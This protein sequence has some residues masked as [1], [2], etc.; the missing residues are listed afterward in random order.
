MESVL[1]VQK[2]FEDLASQTYRYDLQAIAQL[3]VRTAVVVATIL[4]IPDAVALIPSST[5]VT[6]WIL[7]LVGGWIT[8]LVLWFV[9][10]VSMMNVMRLLIGGIQ[11]GPRGVKL[12]RYGRWLSWESICAISI[13]DETLFK[14]IFSFERKV[15]RL[16]LF[17]RMNSKSDYLRSVVVPNYI[18]SFFFSDKDF[19]DMCRMV[20][21]TRFAADC[22]ANPVLLVPPETLGGVRKA[23][24]FIKWQR[25]ILSLIITLSVGMFLARRALVYYTYNEGQHAY[26]VQAYALAEERFR[27]AV[28][29]ER[30]FAPAWHGLAGSEFNLGKFER[31]REHWKEALRWKPDFVEAKVSLAY[32]SLQQRNFSEAEKLIN[33]ALALAPANPVALLNRADLFLRTGYPRAATQDARLVVSQAETQPTDQEIFMATCLLAHAKLVQGKVQEASNLLAPLPVTE[34]RLGM[35]ENLTYRLLVGARLALALGQISKAEKLA[36]MALQR[37]GNIDTLLVMAQVRLAR[38]DYDVA[39]TILEKCRSISPSDPWIY[40]TACEVNL[41]RNQTKSA[42]TNL[43]CAEQCTPSNPLALSR[44]AE[45]YIK[46][47]IIDEAVKAASHSLKLEPIN[48]STAQTIIDKYSPKAAD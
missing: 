31:A 29:I 6:A 23:H 32:M 44:I 7:A 18:A 9:F 14:L 36:R 48:N 24:S 40:I 13:E 22:G 42:I 8:A 30:S 12:W 26:R 33:S 43:K 11:V 27:N 21:Q 47:G 5:T 2:G 15:K 19:T 28:A 4:S 34:A 41:A 20:C 37:G 3:G 45:L 16:T 35:G 1:T 17:T 46:L 39:Q 10:F 38:K 25:I